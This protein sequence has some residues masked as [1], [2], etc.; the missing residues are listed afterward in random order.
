[1][2]KTNE[3]RVSNRFYRRKGFFPIREIQCLQDDLNALLSISRKQRNNDKINIIANIAI[4]DMTMH[5]NKIKTAL[6]KTDTYKV[7]VS[8]KEYN[9][10]FGEIFSDIM[11]SVSDKKGR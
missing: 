5:L 8:E 9:E 2:A 4:E 7:S 1:M 6:K 11:K 10:I 3:K